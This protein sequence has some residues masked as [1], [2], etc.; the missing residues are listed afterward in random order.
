MAIAIN[1]HS[2]RVSTSFI[3]PLFFLS[4]IQGTGNLCCLP[5]L[6]PALPSQ[7]L[8]TRDSGRRLEPERKVGAFFLSCGG[9]SDGK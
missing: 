3:I 1:Q 8:P 9:I 4:I 2:M 5:R 7:V 6:L